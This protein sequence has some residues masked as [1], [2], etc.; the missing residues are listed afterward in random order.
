[1]GAF[2]HVHTI[3]PQR[4]WAGLTSRAVHGEQVTLTLIELEPGVEVPEHSHENEQLGILI[5]GSVTFWIG[6]ERGEVVPGGTWRIL[7][8]VPHSV[9]A[10]P[11]GAVLAE[12]FSPPRADW[13]AI[14]R[15][16]PSP[17][18]WP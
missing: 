15:G 1:L 6:G 8:H 4:I 5:Q 9:S 13:G 2:D 7:A 12:V 17:G 10:G 14:E 18:R 16:E 3:R 11:D